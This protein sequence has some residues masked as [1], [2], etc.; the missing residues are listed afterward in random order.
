MP[1]G[2]EACRETV[3]VPEKAGDLKTRITENATFPPVTVAELNP[4]AHCVF[5]RVAE[6]PIGFAE[7]AVAASL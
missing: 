5:C 2:F 4:T 6:E 3:F 7:M 1:Q